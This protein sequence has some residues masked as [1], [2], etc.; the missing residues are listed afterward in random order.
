MAGEVVEDGLPARTL[1]PF[2]VDVLRVEGFPH[3]NA[4]RSG[5]ELDP[6]GASAEL[7][8]DQALRL[9]LRIG[10]GKVESCAAVPRLHAEGEGA[11]DAQVDAGSRGMPV[12]GCGIP[13][14]DVLGRGP[15]GPHRS[16]ERRVGTGWK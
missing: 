10:A 6:Q 15:G 5:D 11:A 2:G 4:I 12:I 13:L 3:G 14:G 1:F 9:D 16:E 8:L 7:A